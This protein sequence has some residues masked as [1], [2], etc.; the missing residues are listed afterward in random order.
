MKIY[1][2]LQIGEFHLNH[3]EDYL[4]IEDFGKDKKLLAVMDGCTMG[5]DSYLISTLVG[6]LLKKISRAHNY[7]ELYIPALNLEDALK[8]IIAEL[9]TELRKMQEQLLLEQKDLLTTLIVMLADTKLNERIIL[10]IGDGLVSVNGLITE[11]DQDNKPDYLGFHLH[12]DFEQWYT[13]LSQKI[14]F[15][16]IKD[17]SIATDGISLFKKFRNEPAD[18]EI[19]PVSFLVHDTEGITNEDMLD[20]KLKSLEHKYGYRPTDDIAVIRLLN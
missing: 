14:I 13:S 9:F 17:I 20:L 7:K 18:P 15:Q 4:I 10:A 1:T 2:A 16:T 6:K 19:D 3:C 8:S 11:F 12:E 5:R